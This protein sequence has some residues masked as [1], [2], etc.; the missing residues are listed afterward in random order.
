[1][2]LVILG[3]G[4]I[5]TELALHAARCG[6]EVLLHDSDSAAMASAAQRLR[7]LERFRPLLGA[8]AAPRGGG[9]ALAR[10]AFVPEP[11]FEEARGLLIEAIVE[12]PDAKAALL[13]RAHA[14]APPDVVFAST[15]SAV[16]IGW[17]AA[18]CGRPDRL[19]GVHLMNPVTVKHV[20]EVVRGPATSDRALEAALRWLGALGKSAVVVGDRAGFVGN[21][22][23]MLAINEAIALL[24]EGEENPAVVD[25]VFT[26][27]LGH[28]M[29]P[30]A[31]ADL[32]GLDTVLRTL[33]VIRRFTGDARFEARPSLRRRVAEGAL[34]QKAGR[35]IYDYRA[36]G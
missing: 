26:G 4:V 12:D 22:V 17:L 2:R 8:Q 25:R 29:G 33:Q 11:P 31:L 14:A 34:G 7:L 20:V 18:R 27:C 10:I 23:L 15:T 19:V 9:D 1:M 36:A 35:G 32:I 5:G 13:A 28:P 3:A 24:E 21:R 30:L 16:P 6:A